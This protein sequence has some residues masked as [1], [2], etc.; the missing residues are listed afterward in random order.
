MEPRSARY[1]RVALDRAA[2]GTLRGETI[3]V[4]TPEDF[5]VFTVLSTRERDLEDAAT[6]LRVLGSRLEQAC[7]ASDLGALAAEI[8]DHDIASRFDRVRDL[9]SRS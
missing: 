7:I 2:E 5:V 6:V 3:R 8:T 1:A 4:L 9:A